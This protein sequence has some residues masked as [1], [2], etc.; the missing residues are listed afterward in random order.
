MSQPEVDEALQQAVN[1]HL[2]E[3]QNMGQLTETVVDPS[4]GSVTT[5]D[6]GTIDDF[7]ASS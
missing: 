7:V 3:L 6:A 5:R 2:D 4:T 1:E